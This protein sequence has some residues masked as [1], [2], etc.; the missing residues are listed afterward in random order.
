MQS[1]AAGGYGLKILTRIVRTVGGVTV[2]VGVIGLGIMVW[3][4]SSTS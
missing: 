3:L 2:A 1:A 4:G